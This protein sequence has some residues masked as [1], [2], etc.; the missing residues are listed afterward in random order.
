MTVWGSMESMVGMTRL[1]IYMTY[2]TT[3]PERQN[4]TV[5]KLHHNFRYVF[6][7]NALLF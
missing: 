4:L 7:K 2:R 1:I 5:E 3:A 6:S